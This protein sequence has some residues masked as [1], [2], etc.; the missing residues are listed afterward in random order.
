MSIAGV[1]GRKLVIDLQCALV[2]CLALRMLKP[3]LRFM[4]RHRRTSPSPSVSGRQTASRKSCHLASVCFFEQGMLP[5][6]ARIEMP[7]DC[8]IKIR[9]LN[10]TSMFHEHD[11]LARPP[12][13]QCGKWKG[14]CLDAKRTRQADRARAAAGWGTSRNSGFNSFKLK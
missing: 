11:S 5:M 6:E 1:P 14:K 2:R 12:P 10:F 7:K 9:F 4:R 8:I 3:M 13:R